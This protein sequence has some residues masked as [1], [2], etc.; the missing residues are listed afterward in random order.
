MRVQRRTDESRQRI[1]AAAAALQDAG[2]FAMVLEGMPRELAAHIT[3]SLRIPTIGIGAGPDCDAQVLV[4]YDLLGITRDPMPKFVKTFADIGDR[5][6]SAARA[7]AE[8]VAEGTYPDD[9]HS[10]H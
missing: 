1:L 5:I 10:Y 3:E 4:V 9:S 6:V 2:A 8:E 7:F